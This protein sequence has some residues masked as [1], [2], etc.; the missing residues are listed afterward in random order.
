VGVFVGGVLWLRISEDANQTVEALWG[1][2]KD[3]LN[4]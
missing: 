3:F 4:H 1:K 2:A